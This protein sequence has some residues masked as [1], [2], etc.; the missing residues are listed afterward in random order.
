MEQIPVSPAQGAG[1]LAE[2]SGRTAGPDRK[3]EH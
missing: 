2:A 1:T 3:Q